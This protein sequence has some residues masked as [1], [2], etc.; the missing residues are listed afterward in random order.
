MLLK[1]KSLAETSLGHAVHIGRGTLP[2]D[3]AAFLSLVRPRAVATPLVRVGAVHDGGYLLPDDLE[4]ISACISPGVSDQI[5]F[6]M[7]MAE[8]GIDVVMADASVDGPPVAHPRF[9]FTRRFLETFED[10]RHVRLDRLS[11]EAPAGDKVLQMDIE[12]AEYR[13]LLD[14]DADVLRDFRIIVVEF[15][16]LTQIFNRFAFPLVRATFQKLLRSHRVV[17]IHPN[18]VSPAIVKS[19]LAVPDVMEFTFWRNDRADLVEEGSLSFPHPLDADNHP[20]LPP[21]VLPSCWR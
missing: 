20:D 18:N 10:E 8:R 14:A 5:G 2:G 16:H 9:R 7:A 21:L 1:L 3:V 19:G 4:G 6:D 13:V 12:G 11:S 15:H 17:H